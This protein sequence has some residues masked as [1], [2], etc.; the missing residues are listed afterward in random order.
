M[1]YYINNVGV[2]NILLRT[3]ILLNKL[4]KFYGYS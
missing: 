2:L 3:L 1:C 4:K